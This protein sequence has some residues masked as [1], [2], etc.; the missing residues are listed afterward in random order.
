M[1]MKENIRPYY[2]QKISTTLLSTQHNTTF[3]SLD[4]SHG[5]LRLKSLSYHLSF[6]P[7][8]ADLSPIANSASSA[9][10]SIVG[11]RVWGSLPYLAI[12]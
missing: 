7:F 8:E 11:I 9:I 6:V 12:I 4:Y 1:I 2:K 3:T 5:I 10:T